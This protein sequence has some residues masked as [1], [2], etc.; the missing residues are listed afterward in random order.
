QSQDLSK[1][2]AA[3]ATAVADCTKNS[4]DALTGG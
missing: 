1:K 3:L 4:T 2:A